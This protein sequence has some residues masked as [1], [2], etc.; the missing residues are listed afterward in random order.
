MTCCLLS[1]SLHT[2]LTCLLSCAMQN[3]DLAWFLK[4]WEGQYR[5]EWVHGAP[6]VIVRFTSPALLQEALDSLGGGVRGVFMVRTGLSAT[7]ES[8]DAAVVRLQ[9]AVGG[10]VRGVS[11]VGSGSSAA[12]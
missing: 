3:V 4:Q 10:G 7:S 2:S 1:E 9:Q 6:E 5:M 11:L 12:S 8:G